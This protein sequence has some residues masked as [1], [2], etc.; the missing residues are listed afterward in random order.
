MNIKRIIREEM[1]WLNDVNPYEKA[2][3]SDLIRLMTN[4]MFDIITTF[5]FEKLMVIFNSSCW[6]I[7][8]L[9]EMGALDILVDDGEASLSWWTSIE[10]FS[11]E[12]LSDENELSDMIKNRKFNQPWKGNLNIINPNDLKDKFKELFPEA[13]EVYQFDL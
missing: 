4:K 11:S 3:A 2:T 1:D 8:D 13:V 9:G 7:V 12:N 10:S 5:S 6:Y